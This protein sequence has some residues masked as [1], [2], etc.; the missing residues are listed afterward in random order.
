MIEITNALGIDRRDNEA[1]LAG[2][3]QQA[4]RLENLQGMTNRLARDA[5]LLRNAFLRQPL[6]RRER[7]VD[8]G[9]QQ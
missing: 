8:H 9:G 4:A 5:E 6:A 7:P 1:A 3:D 2:L